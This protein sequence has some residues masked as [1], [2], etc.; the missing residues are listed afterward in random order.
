MLTRNKKGSITDLIFIVTGV[1]G[2]ALLAIIVAYVSS[3]INTEIQGIGAF[4][5]AAKEASSSMADGFPTV[6]NAGI[7]FV[8]FALVIVSL[9]LAAMIPVH[10]I[11]IVFYI[12]EYLIIVWLTGGIA[13]AYQAVIESSVF[14][15]QRSS[16][17]LT[18]FLFR[19]SP[20][21][22][23]IVGIALM[24]ITYKAKQSLT[25]SGTF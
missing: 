11:F 19:Y 5:F 8:F 13:N 4:N 12:F 24:I 6:I 20:I 15:A 17:F 1:F 23:G 16:F 14:A 21:I 7:I 3:S 25:E 18:E 10:P 22:I 9:V 2:M